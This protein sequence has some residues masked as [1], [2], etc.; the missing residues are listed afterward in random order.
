MPKTRWRP[1]SPKSTLVRAGF[2]A[3]RSDLGIPADFPPEVLA[4]AEEAAKRVPG[5]EYADRRDIEFVTIDPASS[6]DLDQ[7]VE[8]ERR[9]DGYRVHYAIADLAFFVDPGGAL[10]REVNRRGMTVYGPDQ[11][12]GLHPPVLSEGAA[13]LLPDQDR[14]AVLWTIDLNANGDIVNATAKRALVRSRAKLSYQDAQQMIDDGTG[15]E[16]IGLLKE[17]GLK[18]QAIEQKRGGISLDVPEQEVEEDVDGDFNLLFRRTLPV[19][20]WNAQISL[21]TGMAAAHMMAKKKVGVLRTLPPADRRDVKRLRATA[22]ALDIDWPNRMSYA[23]LLRT[24]DSSNPHH[25]AFMTEATRLFR[26]AG[27]ATFDQAGGPGG[28]LAIDISD[29]PDVSDIATDVGGAP[30]GQTP[31]AAPGKAESPPGKASRAD[32]RPSRRP[33]PT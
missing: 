1:Y 25:A 13:S 33:T 5:P 8:I 6:L 23:D 26:G 2:D 20:G 14:P 17:V 7:A 18:R 32:T 16:W 19:E 27:Y 29:M 22:R 3:L 30:V 11:R 28:E 24:L 9:A 4:E 10:D 21:L 12:V 31:L 15:P